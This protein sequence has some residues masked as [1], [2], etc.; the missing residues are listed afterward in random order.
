MKKVL[1]IGGSVFISKALVE[2]LLINGNRVYV[3][4]RGLRKNVDGAVHLYAD[5][6]DY[7]LFQKAIGTLEF[8]VVYDICA[9]YPSQSKIAIEIL[10]GKTEHF[11]HMSSATV[12]NNISNYPISEDNN[13]GPSDVWGDYSKNKYLCE[14]VLF[15]AWNA[16]QFPMTLIRPFYIYGPNNN[17]D[18]ESYIY[19]RILNDAPIILPGMGESIVQFS[20][21]D[22][23]I[24]TL[25][26][27]SNVKNSIGQAYN[28]LGDEYVSFLDWVKL[29][30][31]ILSREPRI[32]FVGE[33]NHGFKA[34]KWFPFRDFDFYG[35]CNK[36]KKQ[37][38][39]TSKYSLSQ[40]L[41]KTFENYE[42][43]KI[44]RDFEIPDIEKELLMIQRGPL[45]V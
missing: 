17:F 29:C 22:D 16:S 40:G 42:K 7:N 30:A 35:N 23:I 31:N 13:R 43:N 28:V 18:R 5:R 26:N 2:R 6:N 34:R 1:V 44:Q 10:N 33:N 32:Y 21:I 9:Y 4:N 38:G 12:Y 19:K 45:V 39:I 25:V 36:L 37:I 11:I 14:E 24:D 27:L 8:D 20:Y 41:K 15:E 3:L